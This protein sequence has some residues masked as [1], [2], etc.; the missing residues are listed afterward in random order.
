MQATDA[1]ATPAGRNP[2]SM[3]AAS[4]L[5][6]AMMA[7]DELVVTSLPL[8]RATGLWARHKEAGKLEQPRA[9]TTS[10]RHKKPVQ[11][12]RLRAT[13]S[14]VGRKET[15]L[16]GQARATTSLGPTQ[17]GPDTTKQSGTETEN[18]SP[19]HVGDDVTH[20]SFGL[21]AVGLVV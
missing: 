10:D 14:L 4:L 9:T 8:P 13:K 6:C 15:V 19:S 7:C 11:F 17:F 16:L 1:H 18:F 12:R 3:H 20:H 5:G 21:L 2:R